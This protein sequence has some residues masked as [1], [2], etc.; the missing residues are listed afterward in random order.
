MQNNCSHNLKVAGN[1]FKLFARALPALVALTVLAP[2]VLAADEVILK[3]AVPQMDQMPVEKPK[4]PLQAGVEHNVQHSVQAPV[5]RNKQKK[6]EAKID[7]R[8]LFN[9]R[10]RT[11]AMQDGGE[12]SRYNL[13]SQRGIG[14]I[15]VRFL[16]MIGH[17]PVINTVF[18]G[19]PAAKVGVQPDDI[20]VAV[21][22][23]PTH[24]LTR[25][26]CYD[27]IVGTPNTPVTLSLKR[28]GTF[29]VRTMTR[30]D[31][32]DIRDPRVQQAYKAGL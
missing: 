1:P 30:M 11:G 31:F 5:K 28:S 10:L 26:E 6:I 8:D 17:Q 19:T 12:L 21:D 3:P 25:D 22:G 9:G 32:L 23:V 16:S 29:F 14:I 2:G 15:G 7:L 4:T 13:E 27:L 20:I 18:P 24:G